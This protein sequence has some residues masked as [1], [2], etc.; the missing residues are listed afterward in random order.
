M[1]AKYLTARQ[2]AQELG[3]RLDTIY[4]L[5]WAGKLRAEKYE[6]AWKISATAVKE[7]L[8]ARVSAKGPRHNHEAD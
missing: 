2:A 3:I 8:K 5:I 6:G 7:R 1:E 4:S